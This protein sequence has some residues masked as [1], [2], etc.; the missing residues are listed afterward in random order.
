MGKWGKL[1]LCQSVVEHPSVNLRI[2]QSLLLQVLEALPEHVIILHEL[3]QLVLSLAQIVQLLLHRLAVRLLGAKT[4]VFGNILA[5]QVGLLLVYLVFRKS[6]ILQ[7]VTQLNTGVLLRF[8]TLHRVF[9]RC[10]DKV[11]AFHTVLLGDSIK[12]LHYFAILG[13][14][15][16]AREVS[17]YVRTLRSHIGNE[18]FHVS[19]GM[20]H[21]LCKES[22]L[23][24]VVVL[25]VVDNEGDGVL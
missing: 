20:L 1:F 11:F 22:V 18:S 23:Q 5:L 15:N 21:A 8:R 2:G 4:V 24:V 14:H 17:E 10:L 9:G 16:E 12:G 3:L 6:N 19:L 25:V 13:I 7:C